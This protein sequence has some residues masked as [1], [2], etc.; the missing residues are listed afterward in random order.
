MEVRNAF[1]RKVYSI[2]CTCLGAFCILTDSD[3]KHS[4]SD[5]MLL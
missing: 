5:C 4:L 1:V 3:Y 2:L